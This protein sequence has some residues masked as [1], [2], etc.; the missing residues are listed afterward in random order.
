MSYKNYLRILKGG[1]VLAFFT[2]LL[3]FNNLFFPFIASKQIF[4]NILI[5]I[6]SVFAVVFVLKYPKRLKINLLSWSLLA[7]LLSIFV[8]M[9]F[10]A[11]FGISFFSNA[12]RM[13][14][15]WQIL[16]FVAFYFIISVSFKGWKDWKYLFLSSLAVTFFISVK[17]LINGD[18]K[19]VLGNEAYLAGLLI[20]NL[21]FSILFIIKEKKK[22]KWL[23]LALWLL[24]IPVFISCDITGAYIGLGGSLFVALVFLAIFYKNKLF[25][26]S[27]IVLSSLIVLT[28][29]VSFAFPDNS[30]VKSNKVLSQIT[31]QKNTFQTRLISWEAAMK[32]FSGNP[33][34]GVGIGNFTLTFDKYFD[35]DFYN[36]IPDETRFDRVHNNLLE[37][38]TTTGLVGITTYLLLLITAFVY[39]L[40]LFIYCKKNNNNFNTSNLALELIVLLALFVGY[41]VQNLTIFDTM[42]TFLP[43]IIFLA[44]LNYLYT[45][46]RIMFNDSTE[47]IIF[48]GDKEIREIEEKAKGRRE[49]FFIPLALV[50]FIGMYNFNIQPIKSFKEGIDSY[51]KI[52]S[53]NIVEG[54][55]DFSKSLEVEHPFKRDEIKIINNYFINNS[56]KLANLSI[57][58]KRYIFEKNI[59]FNDY[60]INLSPERNV[61]LMQRAQLYYNLAAT[62]E[63]NDK[64]EF[65]KLLKIALEAIDKAILSSPERIESY[66]LKGQLNI[67]LGEVEKGK[68][69]F[70]KAITLNPNFNRSYCKGSH[71]YMVI[72]EDDRAWELMDKC[73]DLNGIKEITIS[74]VLIKS[75]N[76]YIED[77]D[78][79]RLALSYEQ[80]CNISEDG[81]ECWMNLAKMYVDLGD[82]K[83]SIKYGNKAL[84]ESKDEKEKEEIAVFL[85]AIENTI[86]KESGNNK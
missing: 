49:I 73:I 68:A 70:E 5:E 50:V 84:E 11:D 53:G 76:H 55:D 72:K 34:F 9:F 56:S 15:F 13:F 29:F 26:I 46:R 28:I 14:S 63:E 24:F 65:N 61:Y 62:Y 32:G 8:S 69:D 12:E 47:E 67:S 58:E 51:K 71:A 25:K 85:K 16:H 82:F 18:P 6:L 81:G 43:F 74:P 38:L 30:F 23:Y 22:N 78:A 52:L 57:D 3:F 79:D 80:Y 77:G 40:K 59:E 60:L 35:S 31:W 19:A 39:W 48:E 7:Y 54:V 37:I 17:S 33:V 41:F 66:W 83:M 10:S 4:F 45:N 2:L 27:S 36:Y 86:K 44:Y 20:F 75:I 21:Y 1:S 42:P 64:E